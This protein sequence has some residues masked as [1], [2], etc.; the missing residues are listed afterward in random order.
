MKKRNVLFTGQISKTLPPTVKHLVNLLN[1]YKEL[2][3][4][5]DGWASVINF[6][7]S[8]QNIPHNIFAGTIHHAITGQSF[9][10]HF[11]IEI[12]TTEGIARI[13]F[14]ARRW[15]GSKDD[16]PTGIFMTN[17]SGNVIYE[18]QRLTNW[19]TVS[20][21]VFQAL[22]TPLPPEVLKLLESLTN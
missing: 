3:L 4:D 8:E 17:E 12:E 2:S 21:T 20:K 14:T 10:P 15:L 6:I 11:W 19:K 5:C 9:T 13:D 16:V 18:G 22:T 7:L 1:P